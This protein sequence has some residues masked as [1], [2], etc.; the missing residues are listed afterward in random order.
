MENSR[1]FA[2]VLGPHSA[3]DF[4]ALVSG[5][6]L[7]KHGAPARAAWEIERLAAARGWP[8]GKSLGSEAS[9]REQLRVSRETM[10]EAI[11]IV[12]GRGAMRMRRGRS[13]GLVLS[14]PTVERTAASFAAYM[15]ATG[16]TRLEFEQS[17][18]GL[19]QLLAWELA[20]RERALATRRPGESIR[21]W[22]ARASGRQTY[23]IYINTLDELAPRSEAA[24]IISIVPDAL[25]AA[26]A[27]RDAAEIFDALSELP[28]VSSLEQANSAQTGVPARATAIAVALIARAEAAGTPHLGNEAGLCEELEISRSVLRQALRILQDLDLVMVRLGRGGGYVLK[29]P[30]PIGIIRQMFVWLAAR[31]CDP[32][33]LDELRCDLHAANFRLA[34]ELL[35]KMPAAQ[36]NGHCD[37]LESIIDEHV[38]PQRFVHLRQAVAAIAQSPIIDTLGRSIVSYQARS[39]GALPDLG[40]SRIFEAMERKIVANLRG[41]DLDGAERSLRQLLAR[42]EELTLEGF[43]LRTAA[44]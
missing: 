24:G 26:L 29:Q 17:V 31:N 36:R 3:G 33:A 19:D 38:G 42:A 20:D 2:P 12:E 8:A 32:F 28:F 30:A 6:S 40:P 34:G 7:E 9:L 23:L 14:R 44:E 11:R 21:H 16:I 35:G 5:E 10:R 4:Y 41:G 13:G 37:R 27:R 15:R 43:G 25:G 22:L 18:R 1:L 39:Y